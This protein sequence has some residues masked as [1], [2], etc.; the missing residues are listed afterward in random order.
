MS[1]ETLS[2]TT[3]E[4]ERAAVSALHGHNLLV[5]SDGGIRSVELPIASILRIGRKAGLEIIVD[6]PTVSREH[7]IIYGGNPPSVEDLGSR[8]GTSVQ[9]TRVPPRQ[10]V[11]LR[12]GYIVAIG[13]VNIF[14]RSASG[15]LDD[16]DPPSEQTSPGM[17]Q[18]REWGPRSQ[19]R[20]LQE[21]YD[22]VKLIAQ[23]SIPI[24][25]CGE[26]G[27]GKELLA[28][29]VHAFSR[30]ASKPM[31]RV[32]C[33]AL[34]EGILASELFG[35]EKGAFTSAHATKIGL[36]EA[37]DGGTLFLDEVGELSPMTQAKLLRVLET[38]EVTRV[39]SHRAKHVD[40][41][42]VSA[43]N[44]DLRVQCSRGE[45]RSDL[46]FRLNGV[47]VSIPPLR[48]RQED[49][50]TLAEYFAA[51]FA[52]RLSRPTPK[53]S[54]EAQE[55]L[56]NHRWPGN[57]RELK[58]VLER[59]VLLTSDDLVTVEV[60]QLDSGFEAREPE[61]AAIE[62]RGPASSRPPRYTRNT[63][64]DGFLRSDRPPRSSRP[65]SR[66]K[67]SGYKAEQLK[68]ELAKTERD[69]IVAALE[70]AGT[71]AAAADLLGIS[72]R[73]LLYKLDALGIPRPR[74]GRDKD[75][76]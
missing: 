52:K 55:A 38:G 75:D 4:S 47:S 23:S 9:G 17:D 32:N 15:S 61:T 65:Q 54:P 19:H 36:F 8:N 51:G 67:N 57:V 46:Y 62:Q 31:L 49:I 24:L 37:A 73:A 71:Q 60:L 2:S 70:Q 43:S 41:R 72:R 48:K 1:D 44:R 53:L 66:L 6:H 25:I 3:D 5:V 39:G 26:T 27:S 11:P 59:A 21:L 35:H 74:K 22:Q 45:F 10:R 64:P 14:V 56:K 30:R 63:L 29:R 33:A 50:I 28:E 16:D 42:V 40:V 76:E 68:A 18:P 13:D 7:A 20:E 34:S 12:T 58:H 69:R